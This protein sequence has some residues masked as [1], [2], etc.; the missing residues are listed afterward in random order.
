MCVFF[1]QGSGNSPLHYA[2]KGGHI[3]CISC[4]I[5]HNA[6]MDAQTPQGLT[7]LDYAKKAGKAGNFEKAGMHIHCVEYIKWII[8]GDPELFPGGGQL[9]GGALNL[10]C[11]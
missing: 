3:Q 9:S 8:S 1:L 11:G 6:D 2:A 7:P 4:L 10:M 5:V